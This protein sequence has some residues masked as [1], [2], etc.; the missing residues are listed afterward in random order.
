MLLRISLC[1]KIRS[2]VW[3]IPPSSYEDYGMSTLIKD[4]VRQSGNDFTNLSIIGR[5]VTKAL[6]SD[7][8]ALTNLKLEAYFNNADSYIPS[9][10]YTQLKVLDLVVKDTIRSYKFLD[11]EIYSN[12]Y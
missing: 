12:S 5:N 4:I 8:P 3:I 2:L 9:H 11:E 10:I 6:L 1:K 7:I